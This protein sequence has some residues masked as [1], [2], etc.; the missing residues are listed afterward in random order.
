MVHEQP[1]GAQY[2]SEE[3]LANHKIYTE[4]TVLEERLA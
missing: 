1:I 2:K 3:R 4:R